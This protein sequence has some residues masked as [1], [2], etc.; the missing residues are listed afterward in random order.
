MAWNEWFND[1]ASD[2]IAAAKNI[3]KGSAKGVDLC[4]PLALL[5]ETLK[6]DTVYFWEYFR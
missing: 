5:V 4:N 6:S 2:L 3:E 1:P